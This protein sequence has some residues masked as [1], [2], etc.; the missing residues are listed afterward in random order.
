MIQRIQ[1]VYLLI[2]TVLLLLL[3]VLP[4]A[5]IARGTQIYLFNYQG[6]LLEGQIVKSR[7]FVL[8]FIILGIVLHLASIFGYKN[9]VRQKRIVLFAALIALGLS[10]LMFYYSCFSFSGA[11]VSI[12]MSML[13]PLIAIILDY[14]AI[15]GINKDEA[16]VRSI[17]RIR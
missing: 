4:F 6:F 7:I 1:S 5:E 13:F 10:G 15:L 14:L 17:D 2:S 3:F 11:K 8:I 12:K 16:L 9:R